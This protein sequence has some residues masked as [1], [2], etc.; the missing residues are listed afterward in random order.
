MR[1]A[2]YVPKSWK[3]VLDIYFIHSRQ[4]I[5]LQINRL[6]VI[7]KYSARNL[8]RWFINASKL[9]AR[10]LFKKWAGLPRAVQWDMEKAESWTL[11]YTQL[12]MRLRKHDDRVR[13]MNSL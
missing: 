3:R 4:K 5:F 8:K 9:G 7:V 12:S 6:H 13:K 2:L 1:C 11:C 10:S